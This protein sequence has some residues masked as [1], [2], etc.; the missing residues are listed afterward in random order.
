MTGDQGGF[1]GSE[2]LIVTGDKDDLY[3]RI[4]A[5]LPPWFG[6][7]AYQSGGLLGGVLTGIAGQLAFI[8][9]LCAY[10]KLQMRLQTAEEGFLDTWAYDFFGGLVLRQ[11]GQ[12]DAS[13]LNAIRYNLFLDTVTRAA[14]I[15]VLSHVAGNEPEI[16]EAS[17]PQSQ[18]TGGYGVACGYGSHG[19]YASLLMPCQVFIDQSMLGGGEVTAADVYAAA[20][21]TRATGVSVWVNLTIEARA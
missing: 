8:Y 15:K 10:A 14:F 21:S 2:S 18:Q 9:S 20:E 13:F 5:L 16:F 4:K 17:F 3:A 1:G 6:D 11:S 12:S 19:R 7:K